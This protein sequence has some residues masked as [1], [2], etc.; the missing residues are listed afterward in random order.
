[1]PS[2]GAVLSGDAAKG[3]M[4]A[5][6]EEQAGRPL[7]WAE[8]AAQAKQQEP[9]IPEFLKESRAPVQLA[10]P[11]P[12]RAAAAG[13]LS[14]PPVPAFALAT[15]DRPVVVLDA[16]ALLRLEALDSYRDKCTFVTTA[17][18][19]QEVRDALA[20]RRLE[21][22]FF[23]IQTVQPTALD[24]GWAEKFAGMTG[25]L[26][27][28]SNTD[29]GLIALTYMLQRATGQTDRLKL[30][31]PAFEYFTEAELQNK[32]ESNGA[33]KHLW[34]LQQIRKTSE[35]PADGERMQESESGSCEAVPDGE[36]GEPG[37]INAEESDEDMD[38]EEGWVTEDVLR[39]HLGLVE[40]EF[41]QEG[42]KLNGD[43]CVGESEALAEAFKGLQLYAHL[44]EVEDLVSCMTTDFS[45]QNVLL[46]M[47]LGVLA[48]D[49]KKIRTV[50][51]WALLCR[52]CRHIERK[53]KLLFCPKCGHYTLDRVPLYFDQASGR[54]HVFDGRKR[55]SKR[56]Q[57]YSVPKDTGGKHSRP[58]ILAADQLMMGGL[59]RELR[60]MEK[61]WKKDVESKNPFS[62]A[63]AEMCTLSDSSCTSS[64]SELLLG[65]AK[66]ARSCV[67]F[68]G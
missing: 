15:K 1:M 67:H 63:S 13:K 18:A 2:D 55:V 54:V 49:G 60:H 30:R 14:P 17:E 5:D 46:Q 3:T 43:A 20:R 31:P 33:S 62:P 66:L 4:P 12:P 10:P 58:I 59:D 39:D 56:G 68:F 57:V 26:P 29:L 42:S 50:K 64:S 38:D 53:T 9:N 45:I 7:S 11:K 65:S 21:E 61:L 19:A 32:L 44:Q 8:R 6:R 25:D 28:L 48:V 35:T 47:G 51:V 22:R 40:A 23:D 36:D 41:T 52:G 16:G 24:L 27:F 34:T 37:D